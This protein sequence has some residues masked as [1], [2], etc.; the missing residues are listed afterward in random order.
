[1]QSP[2]ICVAL[3]QTFPMRVRGADGAE[4]EL[5]APPRRVLPANAAWVDF[6]SLLIGPERVLA[7][8]SEAFGYSRLSQQDGAWH[9]LPVF[10]S[11]DAERCLSMQPDL[12]LAHTWQ[13][14]EMLE[15]LRLSGIPAL[16][17]PVP[18]TWEEIERTL[19]LLATVLGVSDR[20]H[21]VHAELGARQE[22]LA[23]RARPFA[24]LRALAYTNLGAGGWTTGKHT[25]TD[26]MLALAGLRNAAAEAGL[27][28]E[29]PADGERLLALDPDLFVV[30][31]PD[32]SESAPPSASFLLSEPA[33]QELAAVREK[34]IVSLPPALFTTASPELL[35]GAE[36]VIDEL[37]RLTS[38]L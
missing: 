32:S 38:G 4:I 21:A 37:E 30:G 34:R 28:G 2:Q 13:S 18:E 10:T 17:V 22:A 5:A 1:M 16:V 29:V 27:E 24:T 35:R 33:L 25:T 26:V 6:V 11:L 20:A 19:D 9:S 3:S 12:V 23:R 36:V 31:R 15:T 8:P 14:P 7:L